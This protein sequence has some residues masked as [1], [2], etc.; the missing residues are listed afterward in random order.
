[1]IAPE[2]VVQIAGFEVGEAPT[3]RGADA[4]CVRA[5]P[6]SELRERVEEAVPL[7]VARYGAVTVR[8]D[9]LKVIGERAKRLASTFSVSQETRGNGLGR[10]A[11]YAAKRP[12]FIIELFCRVDISLDTLKREA[13]SRKQPVAKKPSC[14]TTSSPSMNAFTSGCSMSDTEEASRTLT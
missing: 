7:I 13:R 9:F 1:M 5:G 12:S 11:R 6:L 2:N 3:A 14:D 8:D 4:A 10:P